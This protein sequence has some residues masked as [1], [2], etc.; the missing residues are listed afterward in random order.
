[1]K[2]S[3]TAMSKLRC[4][5]FRRDPC[6]EEYVFRQPALMQRRENPSLR[7]VSSCRLTA[8]PQI[9]HFSG[10]LIK[11]WRIQ[12]ERP[13]LCDVSV[14]TRIAYVVCSVVF[15][16]I[17]YLII[18]LENNTISPKPYSPYVKLYTHLPKVNGQPIFFSVL[19][20]FIM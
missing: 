9:S 17:Y 8:H 5:C 15:F 18:Q 14:C 19:F 12:N 6:L 20:S 2:M 4:M 10:S 11:P 3:L 7:R 13:E 16:S 1:M